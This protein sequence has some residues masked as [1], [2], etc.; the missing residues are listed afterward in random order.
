M[1]IRLASKLTFAPKSRLR[2]TI[3]NTIV[4]TDVWLEGRK[5]QI[6]GLQA[7]LFFLSMWVDRRLLKK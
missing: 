4:D 6:N 1:K 3:Q 2:N 7:K 5:H